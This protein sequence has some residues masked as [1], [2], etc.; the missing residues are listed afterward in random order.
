ML[1]QFVSAEKYASLLADGRNCAA[2]LL[3]FGAGTFGGYNREPF[4]V[5]HR[6]TDHPYFTLPRLLELCRRLPSRRVLFRAANI[7][8]DVELDTSYDLYKRGLTLDDVIEH[9]EERQAYICVNNPEMDPEYRP[10]IESLLA[11]V[12]AQVD[13]L[14]PGITWYSTYVFISAHDSTTPY[15][16][17]REMNFLLQIRGGKTVYL[18]NPAD[19]EIMTDAQKDLLLARVGSRPSYKPSFESKA[20]VFELRP[21]FGVHHPF[22][23]PH[24]VHTGSE[25]SISLAVTFRTRRS[26]VWTG[27]HAF[28][29]RMRRLGLRPGPVGRVAWVDG[30]KTTAVRAWART[31]SL[32][33]G[34]G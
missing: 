21:G 28:N 13:P 27:A 31:R 23:A 32:L 4:L 3:E 19:S 8:G 11:E 5:S 33:A 12:A 25:L 18:W 30:A 14:D 22:I 34:G 10:V 9:F 1:G 6:L 29:A 15:H 2:P 17:D 20:A 26:D 7:P 16:M 24:R